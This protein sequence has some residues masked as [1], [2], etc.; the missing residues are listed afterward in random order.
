MRKITICTAM[1][2]LTA[3]TAAADITIVD[4]NQKVAVDCAK[5]Q[6]LDLPMLA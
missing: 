3:A 5:E 2:A 4:N 1:L 6:G